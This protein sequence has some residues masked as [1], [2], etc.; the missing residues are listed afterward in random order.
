MHTQK[1]PIESLWQQA[2]QAAAEEQYEQALSYCQEILAQQPEHLPALEQLAMSAGKTGNHVLAGQCFSQCVEYQPNNPAYY[3][4]LALSQIKTNCWDAALQT[5]Q[6]SLHCQLKPQLASKETSNVYFRIAQQL[7]LQESYTW[8]VQAYEKALTLQADNTEA[9]LGLGAAWH[10]L[11]QPEKA[12]SLYNQLLNITPLPEAHGNRAQSLLLAGRL[13]EGFAEYE[14]RTRIPAF[15]PIFTWFQRKPRWQGES[16]AGKTLLI[17]DEQGFGDAFQFIRYAAMVKKRGGTVIVSAK[18]SALDILASTPGVDAVVKHTEESLTATHFDLSIPLMSLPHI[19]GTTLR[20]I[21]CPTA[22]LFPSPERCLKWQS[23]FRKIRNLRVGL[24]WAGNP[25]HSHGLN[26]T[27]TL[28]ALLPLLEIPH[29]RF[30]SLQVG[31]ASKELL[32]LPVKIRPKDFSSEIE[33]FTDTASIIHHLDLVISVDT[34]VA[35]LAGAMGK[36]VFLLLPFANEWRWLT[37]GETSPWYP[38][39]TLF[40]QPAPQ[41]WLLPIEEVSTQ[42]HLL[43]E[44]HRVKLL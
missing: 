32:E 37:Q 30:F 24:V 3:Y 5:L 2:S 7:Q 28:Q 9:L 33:D 31:E 43:A 21:P 4:N 11:R 42:L 29:T 23:H 35:H 25:N 26:R 8:A 36:K 1:F 39:L 13:E 41:N 16:F 20:T 12:I 22:Y 27:C 18:K 34:A 15:A 17:H 10:A 19:L 40:R 38:S 6:K 14:W 44:K